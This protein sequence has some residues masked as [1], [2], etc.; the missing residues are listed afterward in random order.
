ML[1]RLRGIKIGLLNGNTL[2]LTGFKKKGARQA[3]F[4]DAFLALSE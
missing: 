4:N 2:A 1:G 3:F